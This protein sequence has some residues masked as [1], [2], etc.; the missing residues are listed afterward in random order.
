MTDDKKK[1]G[2]GGASGSQ[3]LPAPAP[4]KFDP[5]PLHTKAIATGGGRQT[6]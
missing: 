6:L 1:P 2:N 5:A 3:N 4:E